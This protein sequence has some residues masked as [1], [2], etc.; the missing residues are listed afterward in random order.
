MAS[1]GTELEMKKNSYEYIRRQISND[2]HDIC[3]FPGYSKKFI[4]KKDPINTCGRLR[5]DYLNK[6]EY[7]SRNIPSPD[8]PAFKNKTDARR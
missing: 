8:T 7:N 3:N 2:T 4:N 5:M 6:L 1:G